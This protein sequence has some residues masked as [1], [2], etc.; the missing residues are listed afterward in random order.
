MTDYPYVDGNYIVAYKEG[1]LA[2]VPLKGRDGSSLLHCVGKDFPEVLQAGGKNPWEGLCLHR[3]DTP[4]RGLVLFARTVDAYEKAVA[5]QADGK[6][7]KR[8]RAYFSDGA[9][10]DG[11][12]PFPFSLAPGTVVR[13]AFRP[14]GE[15]RKAVRPVY[16][17]RNRLRNASVFYETK[18]ISFR[19]GIAVLEL[20][21]GFRHQVRSHMAWSGHALDGDEL[22]GGRPAEEFGL[23]AFSLSLGEVSVTID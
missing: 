19:H 4:T 8:Y 17:D 1:G 10:T 9:R 12:E 22:Y 5:I 16:A 7:V 2:T 3:L 14:Y 13:S 20:C 21:R 18:I 15:G 6:F 23:E 11:F